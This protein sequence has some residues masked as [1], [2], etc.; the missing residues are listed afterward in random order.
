MMRKKE[1]S[2][3]KKSRE[4]Q[5]NLFNLPEVEL[6]VEV[7]VITLDIHIINMLRDLEVKPKLTI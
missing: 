2:W 1:I 3:I 7:V 6:I 5:E 4:K